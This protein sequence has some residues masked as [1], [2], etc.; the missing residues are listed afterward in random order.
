[1]IC[2]ITEGLV[3]GERKAR[4]KKSFRI[5]RV[6]SCSADRFFP[7]S[8]GTT[9]AKAKT[10]KVKIVAILSV[11]VSKLM[12]RCVPFSVPFIPPKAR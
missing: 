12:T 3:L 7:S 6:K 11:M 9:E 4:I 1:M 10:S 8:A 5:T 2:L